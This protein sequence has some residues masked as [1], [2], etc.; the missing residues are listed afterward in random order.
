MIFPSLQSATDYIQENLQRLYAQRGVLQGRL[1]AIVQLKDAAMKKNDQQAL[2]QLTSM[3]QGVLALLQEQV[4]LEDRLQPFANY[5]GVSVWRPAQLGALPVL[6]AGGAIVVAG[7]MYLHWE[8]L[9]NQATALD[10]IAK[11]IL[12]ADQADAILNPSLFSGATGQITTILMLA[13]G[14]YAL[15]LFG[16]MLS[17]LLG[18]RR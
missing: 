1:K 18:G 3:R 9:R 8:K 6:L 10:M 5:F 2:G 12:P 14:G 16:P 7:L 15:F 11:G 4:E 13:V 17:N